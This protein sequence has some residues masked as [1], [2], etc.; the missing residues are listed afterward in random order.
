MTGGRDDGG[1]KAVRSQDCQRVIKGIKPRILPWCRLFHCAALPP[2]RP[3]MMLRQLLAS[4]RAR[5]VSEHSNSSK[6][7]SSVRRSNAYHHGCKH[8]KWS[9]E[10]EE[11]LFF[12]FFW[13]ASLFIAS[14][15]QLFPLTLHDIHLVTSQGIYTPYPDLLYYLRFSFSNF[16]SSM[17]FCQVSVRG[18][19]TAEPRV[20]W[21]Q[22][23]TL[24]LFLVFSITGWAASGL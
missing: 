14:F 2:S 13:P 18:G 17:S 1:R 9:K 5:K 11:G 23:L 10:G 16:C 7:M 3:E 15:S 22:E 24:S 8:D 12:F 6:D 20:Q 21:R 4:H 19:G